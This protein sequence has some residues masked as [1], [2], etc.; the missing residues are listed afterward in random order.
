[1]Q[2]QAS[3]LSSAEEALTAIENASFIAPEDTESLA[4]AD[5][6]EKMKKLN[7]YM[8]YSSGRAD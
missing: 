4:D 2:A 5:I 6:T 3:V 1:M 7:Q 8:T